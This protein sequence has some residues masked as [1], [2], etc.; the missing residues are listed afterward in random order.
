MR[1]KELVGFGQRPGYSFRS[2]AVVQYRGCQ[3]VYFVVTSVRLRSSESQQVGDKAFTLMMPY[4]CQFMLNISNRLIGKQILSDRTTHFHSK[5]A[6]RLT[7][8]SSEHRSHPRSQPPALIEHPQFPFSPVLTEKD[9]PA[10]L[11]DLTTSVTLTLRH[12]WSVRG[13]TF[14]G[15]VGGI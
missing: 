6:E 12:V 9:L 4:L 1:L 13:D 10:K 3:N 8:P 2:L 15:G 5:G 11:D 14:W 7:S